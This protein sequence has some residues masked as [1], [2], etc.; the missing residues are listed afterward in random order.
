M[1]KIS[2]LAAVVAIAPLSLY[3]AGCNPFQSAEDKAQEM[4][5]EAMAE[6]MLEEMGGEGVDVDLSDGGDKA[7]V[8]IKDSEGGGEMMFGEKVELPKD[9]SKSV[10]V[11]DGSTP[12]SV[13]RNLGGAEGTML[14]LQSDDDMADIVK[15]YE[16]EY[17][18]DG[19]T[20][21]QS[22]SVTGAEMRTFEKGDEQ[23]VI[24]VGPNDEDEGGYLISINHAAE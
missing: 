22:M 6:K 9:L 21:K 4:A 13:I 8:T 17:E 24:T 5:A 7:T 11:Y 19:W 16:E 2:L 10:M 23:V 12:L 14:T 20:K 18:K 1:K 15:W 3:G